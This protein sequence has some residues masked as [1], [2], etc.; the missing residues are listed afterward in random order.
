MLRLDDC[1]TFAMY[2]Y[3]VE[4]AGGVAAPRSQHRVD[5]NVHAGAHQWVESASGKLYFKT[6]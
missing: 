2:L 4:T 6:K 3:F 5:E 1:G